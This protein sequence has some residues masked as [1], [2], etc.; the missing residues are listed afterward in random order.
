[1]PP[2][3]ERD[4][5]ELALRCSL[6]SAWIAFRGWAV[7][8]VWASLLQVERVGIHDHFFDL[9][10]HSLQGIRLMGEVRD[11]FGVDLEVRTIFEAPTLA[12]FAARVTQEMTRLADGEAEETAP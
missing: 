7:P 12:A 10:G 9:G 11:L 2:S 1:M 5:M 4:G 6:G 3:A 8:E